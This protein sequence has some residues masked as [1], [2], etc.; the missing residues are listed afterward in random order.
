MNTKCK[1][2]DV[3]CEVPVHELYKILLKASKKARKEWL[4]DKKVS[5]L[6]WK[7]TYGE[8]NCYWQNYLKE[9]AMFNLQCD[10]NAITDDGC[11]LLALRTSCEELYSYNGKR[12]KNYCERKGNIIK[13][14]F[15]DNLNSTC[16]VLRTYEYENT[17]KWYIIKFALNSKEFEIGFIGPVRELLKYKVK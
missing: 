12:F 13:I 2:N 7:N 10:D 4:E 5:S 16:K 3:Q 9:E 8:D 17:K 14:A 15:N 6:Y 1:I 11:T